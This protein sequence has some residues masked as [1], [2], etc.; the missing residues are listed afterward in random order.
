MKKILVIKHGSFGDIILS[1]YAI[2]SI[3]AHFKNCEITILTDNKYRTFLKRIPFI[4]KIKIDNRPKIYNLPV[5]LKLLIWFCNNKFDWVFDLQTSKRT[6]IYYS[7]F[8]VFSKFNWS[9]IAKNCSH[10]HL[11]KKRVNM[12]TIE[13]HKQQL[14]IAGINKF[15]N[16]V[17]KYFYADIRQFKIPQNYAILVPGGSFSRLEKR[18]PIE[19]FKK[20]IKYFLKKN[21]TPVIVGGKDELRLY[22]LIQQE[23]LP[24]I[25]LIGKTNYLHLASLAKKSIFIVGND[26]G[27]MHL[28]SAS[29]NSK[30]R[31]IIL[32]GSNSDPKLCS[33]VGKNIK[34]IRDKDIGNIKVDDVIKLLY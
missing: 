6:N 25:N 13:R 34:I 26:T 16:V 2:F 29:S 15:K 24:L 3:H 11:E 18:W 19:N 20:I 14:K 17:W 32:F 12:H 10:P 30:S 28:L 4:K 8:S 33:P 23:E 1:L 27:P 9:G 7:F 31:K 5:H 21:I 22:K